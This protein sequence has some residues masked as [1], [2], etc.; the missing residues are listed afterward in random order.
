M[1]KA[2]LWSKGRLLIAKSAIC[3]RWIVNWIRLA[4]IVHCSITRSH[5]ERS[6]WHKDLYSYKIMTQSILVTSDRGTFK[7]KRKARPSTNV[8]AGTSSWLESYWTGVGWIWPKVQ[9]QPPKSASRFWQLL[10]ES[11]GKVFSVNFRYF[12]KRMPKIWAVIAAKREHCDESKDKLSVF[13]V[14]I[15]F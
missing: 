7:A 1:K 6:W 15:S 5:L 3:R 11:W 2:L 4:I 13:W 8:L 14:L 12:V 9:D 10:Q